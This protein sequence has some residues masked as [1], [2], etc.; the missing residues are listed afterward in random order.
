M[1]IAECRL[2]LH[3]V[4]V[5]EER[6]VETNEKNIFDYKNRYADIKIIMFMG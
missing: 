4:S 3:L 5:F 1:A 2:S 6:R